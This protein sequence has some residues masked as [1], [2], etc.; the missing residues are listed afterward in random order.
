MQIHVN[1]GG[2]LPIYRQIMNQVTDAIAGGRLRP[3]ER[4]ASQRQLAEE[5]VIS[6]LTVKK[7]YDELEREGLIA[8]RRGKGTFV[9]AGPPRVDPERQRQQLR[10]AAQTLLS[11]AYLSGIGFDQ[12]I[13]LLAEI[14]DE[15]EA[16]RR[17]RAAGAG[18]TT[19][20]EGDANRGRKDP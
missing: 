3:G 10:G 7:A 8:T 20:A 13:T 1:P 9:V 4:L 11:R 15:L 18:D 5:L 17:R 16:E 12:L 6:P 2:A 19:A 14:R